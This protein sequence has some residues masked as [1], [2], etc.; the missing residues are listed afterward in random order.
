LTP[1][2][3][4]KSSI[5]DQISFFTVMPHHTTARAV[6]PPY[7]FFPYTSK[8]EMSSQKKQWVLMKNVL[9]VSGLVLKIR[10]ENFFEDKI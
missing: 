9:Y 4:E 3:L 10:Y 1:G 2:D 6:N 7:F 5:T 8:I